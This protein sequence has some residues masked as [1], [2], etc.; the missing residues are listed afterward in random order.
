MDRLKMVNDTYG[1][2]EGDF[3]IN[4]VARCLE[5]ALGGTAVIGRMGGDEFAAIVPV[6]SGVAVEALRARKEAYIQHFNESKK[7]PYPFG[8]SLGMLE[9]VCGDSYDLK[10]AL[11]KADDLLYLEKREKG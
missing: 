7:K 9:C 8:I 6:A 3:T 1:Y 11:D 10:A 2:A 5:Y 4:L